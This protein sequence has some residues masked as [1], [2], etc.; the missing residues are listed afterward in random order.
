MEVVNFMFWLKHLKP[1]NAF[2]SLFCCVFICPLNSKNELA[3]EILNTRDTK[4]GHAF[5]ML[6]KLTNKN[7][8]S[9]FLE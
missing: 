9:P 7:E 1:W 8:Q 3:A 6:Y 5:F 4:F 2:K